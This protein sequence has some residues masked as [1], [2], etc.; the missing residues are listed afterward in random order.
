MRSMNHFIR[1]SSC[2][3]V[4]EP[5]ARP[6]RE[7]VAKQNYRMSAQA[8]DNEAV[9]TFLW[10]LMKNGWLDG[11][12]SGKFLSFLSFSFALLFISR[13]KPDSTR[14][15]LSSEENF[16]FFGSLAGLEKRNFSLLFATVS[17]ERLNNFHFP[18]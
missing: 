9:A 18:S 14:K 13:L 15:K 4:Q 7:F 5:R 16:S 17:V 8:N 6:L 11:W 10:V 12:R 2:S 1:Q 3:M